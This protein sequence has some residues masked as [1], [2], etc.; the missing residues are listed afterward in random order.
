MSLNEGWKVCTVWGDMGSDSAGEQY[1]QVNVCPECLAD[2]ERRD[3]MRAEM[4]E[5]MDDDVGD[6][7]IVNVLGPYDADYGP[8]CGIC[9]DS[10]E[11]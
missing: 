5:E 10:A 4:D 1:P 8:Q 11:E 9:G 7:N 3:R 6:S 2:D